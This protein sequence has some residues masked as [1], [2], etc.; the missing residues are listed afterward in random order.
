MVDVSV[1]DLSDKGGGGGVG[2]DKIVSKPLD[3]ARGP[4]RLAGQG[5]ASGKADRP[6]GDDGGRT[7]HREAEFN[8]I[9][10]IIV[11]TYAKAKNIG[12]GIFYF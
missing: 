9:A 7:R 3:A 12:I 1:A 4:G 8:V 2:G 5:V 11:A 6:P 10:S